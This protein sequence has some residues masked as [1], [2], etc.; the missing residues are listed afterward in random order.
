MLRMGRDLLL[1]QGLRAAG[2]CAQRVRLPLQLR[3]HVLQRRAVA[4][5]R[6]HRHLPR[7][8]GAGRARSQV[9][10]AGYT[11]GE[12][13]WAAGVGPAGMQVISQ[14]GIKVAEAGVTSASQLH[15]SSMAS[16]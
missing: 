4:L 9:E 12:Q 5:V 8:E 10:G 15:V 3:H 13:M 6:L 2:V 11:P 16:G 7:V 1:V 14:H